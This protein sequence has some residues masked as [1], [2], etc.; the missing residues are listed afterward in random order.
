MA[1]YYSVYICCAGHENRHAKR[2]TRITDVVGL[3]AAAE[4]DAAL[5]DG[6]AVAVEVLVVGPVEVAPVVDAAA[7]E[8]LL[9]QVDQV[10][11]VEVVAVALDQLLREVLLQEVGHLQ[12]GSEREREVRSGL[13]RQ[14]RP[15]APDQASGTRQ[16]CN[17]AERI[18][19]STARIK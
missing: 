11:E 18:Q 6:G 5:L 12:D 16:G 4:G 2:L 15:Q 7:L 9:H 3:E 14:I 1:I 8:L 10:L 19:S 17:K 13:R